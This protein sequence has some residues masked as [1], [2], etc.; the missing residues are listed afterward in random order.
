M[1]QEPIW[2]WWNI[3]KNF[4][5]KLQIIGQAQLEETFEANMNLWKLTLSY[6]SSSWVFCQDQ[7]TLQSEK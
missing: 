4:N 3:F 5:E 7:N 2:W 1:E 6:C